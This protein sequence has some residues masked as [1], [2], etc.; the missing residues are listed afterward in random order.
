MA[1]DDYAAAGLSGEQVLDFAGRVNVWPSQA[2]DL[3]DAVTPLIAARVREELADKARATF[4]EFW[5]D[6]VTTGGQLDEA[7]VRLEL[8][9]YHLVMDEVA[10]AYDELT[11]GRISKPNTAAHHVVSEAND[12]AESWYAHLLCE[13]ADDLDEPAGTAL[14]AV[15]EDWRPGAVAEWDEIKASRA[16]NRTSPDSGTAPPTSD[17]ETQRDVTTSEEGTAA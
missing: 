4:D 10:R 8:H 13:R 7:K 1:F 16:R 12:A 15:A 9:D 3:L 14:R 11:H 6:L 2:R 17:D 5:A